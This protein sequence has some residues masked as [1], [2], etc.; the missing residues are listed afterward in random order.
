[1]KTGNEFHRFNSLMAAIAAILANAKGAFE[2]TQAQA[3]VQEMAEG[4]ESRGHGGKSPFHFTGIAAARRE[5]IKA[6]GKA[7]NKRAHKGR[8]GQ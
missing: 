3:K 2:V 1:M 7:K 8:A 4:Y 5:R 6:R